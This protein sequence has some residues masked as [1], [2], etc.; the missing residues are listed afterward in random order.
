MILTQPRRLLRIHLNLVWEPFKRQRQKKIMS[1]YCKD[2]SEELFGSDFED[3]ADLV[4]PG[5]FCEVLC[6]GCGRIVVDSTGKR[7]EHEPTSMREFV[8]KPNKQL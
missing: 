1:D 7:T 5:Q 2:C 4:K 3:L 8:I 6:E